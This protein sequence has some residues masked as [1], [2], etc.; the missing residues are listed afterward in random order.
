MLEKPSG[1]V[2]TRKVTAL[3]LQPCSLSVV[4]ALCAREAQLPYSGLMGK[5]KEK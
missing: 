2:D 3:S 1:V 4:T 5:F